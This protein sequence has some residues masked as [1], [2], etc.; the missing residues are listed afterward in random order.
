MI[1][2]KNVIEN[3]EQNIRWI[4]EIECHQFPGWGNVTMA[5]RDAAELLKEQD[6]GKYEYHYD[7]TDCIWY[8]QGQSV[9][10]PSTCSQYRD[11]WNDAMQYIFHNG[12]GYSPY[13]RE[14]GEVR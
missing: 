14:E 11:G 6:D 4:E 1:D 5:M 10:C 3:L 12:K 7:H 8:R 2:R 13:K 9:D